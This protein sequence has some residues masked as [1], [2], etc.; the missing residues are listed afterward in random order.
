MLE[1]NNYLKEISPDMTR[2]VNDLVNR[3]FENA[4]KE[5]IEA[6]AQFQVQLALH[7]DE[8]EQIRAA[9]DEKIKRDKED[10]AALLK[11]SMDA[12]NSL[13]KLAQEKLKAVGNGLEK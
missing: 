1:K 10:S 5:E 4:T 11:A 13:E 8:V 6:Y 12:L 3:D 2:T 9:R 7:A